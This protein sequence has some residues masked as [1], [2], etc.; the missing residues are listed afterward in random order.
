MRDDTLRLQPSRQPSLRAVADLVAAGKITPI[1][2]G[3]ENR[4]IPS[5]RNE[6]L[7][8]IQKPANG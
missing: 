1:R 5:V 7:R 8:R 2:E 6:E 4:S 3:T